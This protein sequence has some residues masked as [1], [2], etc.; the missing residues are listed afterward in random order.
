MRKVFLPQGVQILTG[1]ADNGFYAAIKAII[2]N[3]VGA[4]WQ[5]VTI[6]MK[7]TKRYLEI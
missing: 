2:W 3:T 7:K 6:T 1:H 4:V 5:E